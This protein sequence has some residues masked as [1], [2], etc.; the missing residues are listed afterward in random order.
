VY[1]QF[2]LANGLTG[3]P[4]NLNNY[5]FTNIPKLTQAQIQNI[6]NALGLPFD[7]NAGVAPI[8]WADN[9]ESPRSFQWN[10]AMEH[11]LGRGW[12]IGGDFVYINTVHLERN[13]DL[14]SPTPIIYTG[15]SRTTTGAT[16]TVTVNYLPDL[17]QRLCNGLRSGSICT[18]PNITV[19]VPQPGGGTANV[20][21]TAPTTTQ[22]RPIPTLNSVQQRE[23]SARALYRGLTFRTALRRSKYQFQA[24]YTLSW[25]YSD[26]DNERSAGGTTYEQGFNLRND[27]NYSDLD[28][29]HLFNFNGVYELPWGVTVSGLGRLRSARPID[30]TAGSFSYTVPVSVTPPAG[31]GSPFNT[32]ATISVNSD[33]NGDF[34]GP[35]R[36]YVALGHPMK[37]NAFRD[38]AVVNFDLRVAKRFNLPREGMFVNFTVDFFNL[39]DNDN[40][41][42]GGLN[43]IYGPGVNP[44]T[45]AVV[46]PNSTFQQLR[47]PA[48]CLSASN[49]RGNKSC[50]DTNNIPGAPFQMQVGVRFQF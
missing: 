15:G 31:G 38:R 1:G 19:A 40:V 23:S 48:S 11:E 22:A 7:P 10:I 26:D 17:T 36:P 44:A 37:R 18:P 39:F 41:I 20:T 2:L 9:Y 45:G 8:T 33:V 50:Y 6:A 32:T 25:N 47:S 46:A 29:R 14:N 43:K 49:P 13:R 5:N 12:S 34:G 16:G 4:I 3:T 30:A 42:Y 28:A 35:D 21:V 27:Y 24:Y